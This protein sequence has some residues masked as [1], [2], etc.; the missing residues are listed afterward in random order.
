MKK[1]LLIAS[2]VVGVTLA[3]WGTSYACGLPSLGID[4]VSEPSADRSI[5]IPFLPHRRVSRRTAL[6]AIT[7]GV[8]PVLLCKIFSAGARERKQAKL[9]KQ[10]AR[11]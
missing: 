7:I 6:W 5:Q 1:L 9:A 3:F 11:E 4:D 8:W 10:P 2:L